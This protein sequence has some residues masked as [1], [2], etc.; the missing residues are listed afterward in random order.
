MDFR[1]SQE[2]EERETDD[3]TGRVD[4]GRLFHRPAQLTE[5][6]NL[7]SLNTIMIKHAC[8]VRIVDRYIKKCSM[9]P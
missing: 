7:D 4:G 5:A 9:G 1:P 8:F 3:G 6:F 2:S